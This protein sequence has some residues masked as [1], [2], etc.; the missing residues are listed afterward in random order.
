MGNSSKS[1]VIPAWCASGSIV[2]T[3]H[4]FKSRVFPAEADKALS[5]QRRVFS[6]VGGLLL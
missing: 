6:V 1:E 5:R 3:A 2:E 4:G